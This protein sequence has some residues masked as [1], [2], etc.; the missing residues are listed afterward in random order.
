MDLNSFRA[1][2]TAAALRY[3]ED[4]NVIHNDLALR[5]LLVASGGSDEYIVKIADFG[6]SLKLE[7][8]VTSLTLPSPTVAI[9]WAAPEVLIEH[10]VSHQVWC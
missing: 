4:M 8:K 5:N 2:Q 1:K 9:R 10:V 7:D 6:L 3:L